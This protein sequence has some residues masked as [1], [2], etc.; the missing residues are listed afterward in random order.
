MQNWKV[1]IQK[2]N[3]FTLCIYAYAFE[4]NN[5]SRIMKLYVNTKHQK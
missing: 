3:H 1:A 5:A 2:K 4:A